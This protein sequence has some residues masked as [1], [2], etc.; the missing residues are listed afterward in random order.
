MNPA[1]IIVGLFRFDPEA[2]L[3]NPEQLGAFLELAETIKELE[4]RAREAAITLGLQGTEIPG[5]SVVRKEGNR[6]VDSVHVQELLSECPVNQLPALLTVVAK[7]L[8]NLG[9]KRWAMLCEAA[10]YKEGERALSQAGA[11]AF[12]RRRS[13]EGN[14]TN[15]N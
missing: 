2:M 14:H 7:T 15:T 11:T 3:S 1:D 6:F 10:G 5:W 4:P 12:L 13:S 8:G 9:E